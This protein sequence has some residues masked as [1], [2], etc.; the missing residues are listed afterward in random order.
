MGSTI[1]MVLGDGVGDLKFVVPSLVGMTYAEARSLLQANGLDFGSKIA[2]GVTDTLNA[3]IYK[4]SPERFDDEGKFRHI[5]SGQLIDVWLQV[6]KPLV[7]TVVA[8][9]QLPE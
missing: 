2:I 3:F 7:D 4:Q 9:P 1:D 8:P 6:E 5:R